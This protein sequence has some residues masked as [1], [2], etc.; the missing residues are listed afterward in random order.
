MVLGCIERGLQAL[1]LGGLLAGATLGLSCGAAD[2]GLGRGC[3]LALAAG[4]GN[5]LAQRLAAGLLGLDLSRLWRA[6]ACVG[7]RLAHLGVPH[8]EL[9]APRRELGELC[10]SLRSAGRRAGARGRRARLEVVQVPLELLP[11]GF[12][13]RDLEPPGAW[14]ASSASL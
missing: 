2:F 7:L 8:L 6:V 12:E 5:R 3:L 1:D 9:V 14:R 4:C 10:S 11:P 13:I